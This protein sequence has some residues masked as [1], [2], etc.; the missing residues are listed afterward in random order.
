MTSRALARVSGWLADTFRERHLFVRSG[1]D[2]SA[3]VLTTRTQLTV[4]GV[5]VV[6]A[7]WMGIATASMIVGAINDS[8]SQSQVAQIQAKYERWIADRQAKLNS[9]VG[10]LEASSDTLDETANSLEKRHAALAILLSNAGGAAGA[11]QA[12]AP[13]LA[14]AGDANR[15]PGDRLEAIRIS[16]ERLIEATGSFAKNRADRL[17]MAFRLAG[18]DPTLYGGSSYAL[19]GPLIDAKDPQALGAVLDIDR[20]FARRVEIA[21]RDLSDMR[22]LSASTQTMPLGRPAGM[23]PETSPFGVRVDPFTGAPAFHPGQDFAGT[24]MSPIEATAPGVVSFTGIRSGYGNTVEIDHGHGFKTRYA[25]L[26]AISVGVGQ[27]V[28]LG[29]RIGAMGDT[30]RSTGTH[31]HY[32]VW[33][34]GR[35]QNPLRFI[36]A[37]DYVHQD[38]L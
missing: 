4:A 26:A 24:F 27:H 17:R 30:G 7:M 2:I 35:P 28:A 6:S 23:A 9:A 36:K 25:H 19:G 33:V 13:L 1:E 21:A 20:D 14:H 18:L 29:Q 16:Q 32:E 5:V 10:Q 34:D 31:L 8:R 3:F 22:G 37:G 11:Q 12:L 38:P 15:S